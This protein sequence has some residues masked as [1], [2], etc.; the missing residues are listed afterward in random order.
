M[1]LGS[2]SYSPPPEGPSFGFD[3]LRE[4]AAAR[5]RIFGE[6]DIAAVPVLEAEV[7]RL[8]DGGLRRLVLD[9]SGLGFLDSTGLRCVLELDAEARQDGFSI[10][11]VPGP[12]AVQRVFELTGT[13][14]RL[15]FIDA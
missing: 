14:A 10:A 6:L 2:D 4:G 12:R 11:L 3:V 7:A 8:R 15:R 13:T 9:L 5:V 1:S